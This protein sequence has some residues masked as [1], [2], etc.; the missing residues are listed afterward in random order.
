MKKKKSEKISYE[1]KETKDEQ[2]LEAKILEE[3]IELEMKNN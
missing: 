2:E 3:N 1:E